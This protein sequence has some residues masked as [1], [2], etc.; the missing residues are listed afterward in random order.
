MLIYIL[1]EIKK[2]KKKRIKCS[3]K[4]APPRKSNR[5]SKIT[6][7]RIRQKELETRDIVRLKI[8]KS[9]NKNDF[10]SI[11]IDLNNK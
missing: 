4:A 3:L 6:K 1:I 2:C 5:S 9:Y 8:L 7:L 11:Y 10:F